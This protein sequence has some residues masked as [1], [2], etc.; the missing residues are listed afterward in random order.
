MLQNEGTLCTCVWCVCV[1]GST[2][3]V[4][5]LKASQYWTGQTWHKGREM[6]RCFF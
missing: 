2:R 6:P 3:Q 4:A 1:C 5:K